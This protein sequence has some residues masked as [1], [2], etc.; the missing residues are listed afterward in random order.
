MVPPH[1]R[2]YSRRFPKPLYEEPVRVRDIYTA[3]FCPTKLYLERFLGVVEPETDETAW[4]KTLHTAYAVVSEL[5]A[6]RRRAVEEV[7]E[8][9]GAK[10]SR[11]EV[12]RAVEK[13]LAFRE[14]NPAEHEVVV[15]KRL[16]S[17]RLGVVGIVDLVEGSVPVE[18][19]ARGRATQPDLVQL[20]WYALLL[21]EEARKPVDVAY[22]DLLAAQ[23][24]VKVWVGKSLRKKAVELRNLAQQML[25][26]PF[27]NPPK[28]PK[29]CSACGLARECRLI[30]GRAT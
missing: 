26:S 23:K 21:E 25:H 9:V 19:K 5:G 8:R 30:T 11:E 18:V 7:L 14:K 10:A 29:S 22:L 24:R 4:G 13:A 17:K 3:C 15:E 20:A 1:L 12:E 2:G 27:S 6:D 16:S 28:N